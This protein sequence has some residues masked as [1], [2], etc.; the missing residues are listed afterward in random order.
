MRMT[1]RRLSA[2]IPL[3]LCL[4]LSPGCDKGP[5]QLRDAEATYRELIDRRVSPMDPAWDPVIAAFDAIAKDS[6]ARPAADQRIAA[7]RGLRGKLPPRPLATPGATGAGTTEAD[8][9][10]AACEA[11]AIRLGQTPEGPEREPLHAAL[12]TCHNELVRLE[13]H[14]HPPGEH[15]HD[16]G[17]EPGH[18]APQG[19]P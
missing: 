5:D 11:L 2:V 8:A 12:E 14:S 7:I 13:A 18:P 17:G 3:A 4:L 1:T 15:A 9:K 6:K 16:H 10:R 19:Q